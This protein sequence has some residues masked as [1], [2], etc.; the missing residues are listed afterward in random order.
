MSAYIVSIRQC[1]PSFIT[2]TSEGI[3]GISPTK[4]SYLDSIVSTLSSITATSKTNILNRPHFESQEIYNQQKENIWVIEND[5]NICFTPTYSSTSYSSTASKFIS[6]LNIIN[7]IKSLP[8]NWNGNGAE[9]FSSR[10]ITK[11]TNLIKNLT[12]QPD[13]FPTGEKSIQLEFENAKGDYLEFEIFENDDVQK[14]FCDS[15]GK[16]ETSMISIENIND[17]LLRKFF[18]C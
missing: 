5:N 7:E 15:T 4:G 10:L 8:K 13:I 11:V 3:F 12:Y 2:S 6:N 16:D 14:F 18:T 1:G 9:P 17:E